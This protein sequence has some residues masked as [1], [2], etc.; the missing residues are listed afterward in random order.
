MAAEIA[1]V[2]AAHNEEERLGDTLAALRSAFPGA[3]MIVADD[4]STDR[5]PDIAREAGAELV[6]SERDVGKGAARCRATRTS[7]C[8]ATGTLGRRQRRLRG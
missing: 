6:R 1:V 2:V 5:T 4:G 8:S 7:W 3:R